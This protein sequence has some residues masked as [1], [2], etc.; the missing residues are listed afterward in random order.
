MDIPC[1]RGVIFAGFVPSPGLDIGFAC[2]F[3]YIM[4]LSARSSQSYWPAEVENALLLELMRPF[5]A[6]N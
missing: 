4:S 3:L 6:V 1:G 2:H 5:R